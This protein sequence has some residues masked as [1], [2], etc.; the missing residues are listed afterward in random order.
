VVP[1][2]AVESRGHLHRC[3]IVVGEGHRRRPGACR[4][5]CQAPRDAGT[6]EDDAS[7]AEADESPARAPR[8]PMVVGGTGRIGRRGG[9]LTLQAGVEERALARR[10]AQRA[11]LAPRVQLREASAAEQVVIVAS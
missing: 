5:D 3:E 11:L 1:D 7:R 9:S 2:G 10:Q 6:R 4:Q 8:D